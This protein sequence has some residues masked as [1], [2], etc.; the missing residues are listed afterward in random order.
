MQRITNLVEKRMPTANNY[1]SGYPNT[2]PN[3]PPAYSQPSGS[4]DNQSSG[5]YTSNVT[6]QHGKPHTY[7]DSQQEYRQPSPQP[8]RMMQ[9][10]QY[11]NFANTSRAI[12]SNLP[13]RQGGL[14]DALLNSPGQQQRR[15]L[16]PPPECFSRAPQY[17]QQPSPFS[18]VQIP[19]AGPRLDAGFPMMYP[20]YALSS[21]DVPEEDWIRFIQDIAISARYGTG[22]NIQTSGIQGGFSGRRGLAGMMGAQNGT[23]GG[24]TRQAA[25]LVDVWNNYFFNQRGVNMT[26]MHGP[27]PITGPNSYQGLETISDDEDNGE[28]SLKDYALGALIDVKERRRQKNLKKQMKQDKKDQRKNPGAFMRTQQPFF[29]LIEYRQF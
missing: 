3:A 29:L 18:P 25:S 2:Y 27:F 11:S 19:C 6:S 4:Y 1:G 17:Y 28:E 7:P 8:P 9:Q 16:D 24:S 10:P 20:S 13:L 5:N 12:M 22:Q 26:L 14:L 23:P 21:H 15:P